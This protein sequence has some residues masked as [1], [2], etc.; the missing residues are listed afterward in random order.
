MLVRLKILSCGVFHFAILD[1]GIRRLS[2]NPWVIIEQLKASSNSEKHK[3]VFSLLSFAIVIMRNYTVCMNSIKGIN[4]ASTV[5][6]Q[7]RLSGGN[8]S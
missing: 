4:H 6:H 8:S 5:R 7:Q 2:F 3:D 1:V